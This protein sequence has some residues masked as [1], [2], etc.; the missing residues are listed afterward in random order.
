MHSDD[1]HALSTIRKHPNKKIEP[2]APN[3]SIVESRT[4][5]PSIEH[6]SIKFCFTGHPIAV[7]YQPPKFLSPSLTPED[8]E[9]V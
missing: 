9:R 6:S 2:S 7:M 8:L 3:L 4:P 5:R 1:K